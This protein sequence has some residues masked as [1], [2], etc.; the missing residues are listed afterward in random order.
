MR[1][2]EA[3]VDRYG[4]IAGWDPTIGDGL[5][6]LSGPNEA[7]KTLYLEAI[8]QLLDPGVSAILDPEPRFGDD[9]VGRV[10]IEHTDG[11]EPLGDDLALSDVANVQP[12]DIP[13]VFVVR[14]TDLAMPEGPGYYTDLIEHLGEVHTSAIDAVVGELQSLG[15][16]TP[17]RLDVSDQYDDA[18]STRDAAAHLVD[19]IRSFLADSDTAGTGDLQ[20]ERIA[21]ERELSRVEEEHAVQTA[22]QRLAEHERLSEALETYDTTGDRLGELS[23]YTRDRLSELESMRIELAGT[24]EAIEECLADEDRTESALAAA[25]DRREEIEDEL[26]RLDR[27]EPAVESVESELETVRHHDAAAAGAERTQALGRMAVLGGAIATG[28]TG[29]AGALSGS[30]AALVLGGVLLVA[31]LLV[32]GWTLYAT[33]QAAA[34]ERAATTAVAAAQDAG[35]EVEA[36]EDIGPSIEAFY[37][38]LE[39]ARTN[40]IRTEERLNQLTDELESTRAEREELE[41]EAA[42]LESRMADAF[43]D[44]DVD[45]IDAFRAAVERHEEVAERHRLARQRLI[46]GLGE[47]DED[48]VNAA[49]ESWSRRLEELVTDIDRDGVSAEQFDEDRLAALEGRLDDLRS[50]R[51]ELEDALEAFDSTLE[52]FGERA[53]AL[54]AQPFVGTNLGLEG[55]SPAALRSLADDLDRLVETI[56]ADADASRRAIELLRSIRTDQQ[57]RITDLFRRDGPASQAFSRITGGLYDHIDYD[58]DSERLV[59]ERANGESVTVDQLSA[60]ATDQLYL[61]SR[62][63]LAERLLDGQTGFLL[64]DDPLVAADPNR[65]R[66]GFEALLRL[67]DDGWQLVYITAKEEVYDGMV[68]EFDLD[69]ERLEPFG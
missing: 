25:R 16:L 57:R 49:V 68:A 31:T 59:A 63:S 7:G 67:V 19:D 18:D 8:V 22:A 2:V 3:A 33:R 34:V 69:H 44:A 9:P 1:L 5:T 28:L 42:T 41:A 35:L 32:G 13:T 26:T 10:V 20:R 52:R 37:D 24:K 55:R 54:N 14:D 51:A 12:S 50:T 30:N 11:R 36:V 61:A 46:D 6:V 64:L 45:D 58:P 40:R 15:R 39:T 27:R 56:E 21:I 66:R 4:P 53:R 43:A 65:L 62:L 47:V 23:S 29:A 48:T 60:G 38:Q 17:T